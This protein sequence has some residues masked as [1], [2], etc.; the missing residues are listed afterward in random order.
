[1]LDGVFILVA[2]TL[3]MIAPVQGG[4]GAFHYIVPLALS[5][6]GI[7]QTN[8]FAFATIQHGTQSLFAMLL[9][10]I[11]FMLI[12]KTLKLNK[13]KPETQDE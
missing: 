3:G 6:Y 2:G 8:G 4:I 9:G 7:S 1:M 5:M 10:A 11:S 13:K 12:Y